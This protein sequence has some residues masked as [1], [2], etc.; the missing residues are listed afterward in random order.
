MGEN[1]KQDVAKYIYPFLS[2][3]LY[4]NEDYYNDLVKLY[5]KSVVNKTIKEEVE[6]GTMSN[7]FSSKE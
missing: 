6:N 7:A 3:N 5:G 4:N 1:L 2:N